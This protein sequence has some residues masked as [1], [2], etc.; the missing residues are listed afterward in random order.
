MRQYLLMN[1][2]RVIEIK[3]LIIMD[4]ILLGGV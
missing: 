4:E 3:P 1:K 2:G